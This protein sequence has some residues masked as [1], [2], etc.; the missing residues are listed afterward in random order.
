[1]VKWEKIMARIIT[2]LTD[3]PKQIFYAVIAGYDVAKITLEWKPNQY[4]WFMSLIWGTFSVNNIR[5][6][7]YPNVLYQWKKVLPFGVAITGVNGQDP[8]VFN[9]WTTNNKFYLIDAT[10]ISEQEAI[11]NG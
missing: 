4:G 7:N 3:D 2:A 5:L 9:A 10:D 11:F 6:C 8:L 1:M